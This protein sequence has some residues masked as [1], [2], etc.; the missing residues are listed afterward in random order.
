M[1]VHRQLVAFPFLHRLLGS[2]NAGQSGSWVPARLLVA[3]L[4]V[5]VPLAAMQLFVAAGLGIALMVS[6]LSYCW[7]VISPLR[8]SQ[9]YLY[10][11]SVS[12]FWCFT[13]ALWL[14]LVSTEFNCGRLTAFLKP[15]STVEVAVVV[16][17]GWMSL[18]LLCVVYIRFW[19]VSYTHLTLPTILRV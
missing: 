6:M 18:Q 13:P 3:W 19:A 1:P 11:M 12:F 4:H 5:G 2:N 7:H 8:H 16:V 14:F 15:F 9:S 10:S 17:R